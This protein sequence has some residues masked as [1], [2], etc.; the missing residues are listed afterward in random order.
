MDFLVSFMLT[1]LGACIWWI[2]SRKLVI[3][4]TKVRLL[5]I[6]FDRAT[7][8]NKFKNSRHGRR[9]IS[10]IHLW[11]IN[12]EHPQ[13][14]DFIGGRRKTMYEWTVRL[15][16]WSAW[17][18]ECKNLWSVRRFFFV[19]FNER[20]NKEGHGGPRLLFRFHFCHN[21]YDW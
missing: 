12:S 9:R 5:G 14:T 4:Y 6:E 10:Q 15:L 20:V 21:L 1:V 13:H 17:Y 16:M 11:D 18:F 2:L 19:S 3:R 8:I 7:I